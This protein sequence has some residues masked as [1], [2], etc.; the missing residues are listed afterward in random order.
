[1]KSLIIYS[2]IA[3]LTLSTSFAKNSF[4]IA[5]LQEDFGNQIAQNETDLTNIQIFY[6]N[7]NFKREEDVLFNPETVMV[8]N[9]EKSIEEVIKENKKI[10]EETTTYES[11]YYVSEQS[12]EETI[13]QDN[14]II[15]AENLTNIQPIFLEKTI[16]DTIQEDNA[17]IESTLT[18]IE[19]P[20]DF[21]KINKRNLK[22]KS[23]SK[24]IGM[25]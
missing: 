7:T 14:Q 17:I 21:E 18:N 20:L 4:R 23:N 9:S 5:S 19:Y 1:M 2:G 6:I 10:I 8:T 12:I 25:N 16:D 11:I 24:I 15:E 3:L 13:H 22:F